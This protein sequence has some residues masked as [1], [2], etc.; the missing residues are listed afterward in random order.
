MW[1]E[2]CLGHGN[3]EQPADGKSVP[4]K[5]TFWVSTASPT[6]FFEKSSKK[7]LCW[8]GPLKVF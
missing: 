7:S 8:K 3:A 4:C 1:H 5:V 2:H 6:H